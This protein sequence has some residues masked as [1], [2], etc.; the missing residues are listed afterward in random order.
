VPNSRG[1][2]TGQLVC[3]GEVGGRDD[4]ELRLRVGW[5]KRRPRGFRGGA[6][7]RRTCFKSNQI[8]SGSRM[9]GPG[10]HRHGASRWFPREKLGRGRSPSVGRTSRTMPRVPS[11]AL[12]GSVAGARLSSRRVGRGSANGDDAGDLAIGRAVRATRVPDGRG[13]EDSAVS[14]LLEQP[15]SSGSASGEAMGR[16]RFFE[17]LL[18]PR[19]AKA[20]VPIGAVASIAG[21]VAAAV[22]RSSGRSRAASWPSPKRRMPAAGRISGRD[23]DTRVRDPRGWGLSLAR[24]QSLLGR[25]AAATAWPWRFSRS[26][27]A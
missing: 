18:P 22:R 13:E 10:S 8:C 15:A 27:T 23:G 17:L 14:G 19:A 12:T 1:A 11:A 26:E 7:P 24:V 5:P 9:S 20:A 4:S 21:F 3:R 25:L 6:S 16:C 2:A